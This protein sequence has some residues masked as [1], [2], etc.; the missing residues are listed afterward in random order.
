MSKQASSNRSAKKR[1][2]WRHGEPTSTKGRRD[3]RV[4]PAHVMVREESPHDSPVAPQVEA[5]CGDPTDLERSL[6]RQADQLADH[7]RTR[8]RELD[9][10][11]G[12]LNAQLAL[13]ENDSRRARLWLAG[14]EAELDEARGDL[15][16]QRTSLEERARQ[17]AEE[18]SRP[19]PEHVER[20]RN[21]NARQAEL[22]AR[23]VR[24]RAWEA[25]IAASNEEIKRLRAELEDDFRAGGETLAE[26]RAAF[27]ERCRGVLD[28]LAEARRRAEEK[29]R[30]A[31]QVRAALESVRARSA[32]DS[33]RRPARADCRR[34]TPYRGSR[35]DSARHAR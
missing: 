23:E 7:L 27:D 17:L 5:V 33:T 15:E 19:A 31:D 28:E 4:D 22:E 12:K 26:E 10:R 20:E 24:L 9:R 2:K 21:L 6:Q 34:G 25:E 32:G 16:Q 35:N 14:R 11:E 18:A 8:R 3:T 30:R 29:S 1:S 13:L